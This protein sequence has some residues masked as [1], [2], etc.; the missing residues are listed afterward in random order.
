MSTEPH[1][2][3]GVPTY[4][5]DPY[6]NTLQV[7]VLETGTEDGR[8]WVVLDDTVLFPEGGGQGADHGRLDEIAVLDVQRVEGKIRHYLDRSAPRIE[9]ETSATLTLDWDRRWDHMQQH[10]AQHLL[11]AIAADRFGWPT[12]AFH[13]RGEV[14]DIE[15][16]APRLSRDDLDRLE[17]AVALEITNDVPV[18]TRRVSP[19]EYETMEGVRSRGL[20]AGHRGD[21]RLVE[22]AGIDLNTCGGTHVRSTREIECLKLL[23]TETL[24]G[25]TRLHWVAG[26]RVRRRLGEHEA[27]HAALRKILGAPDA[28]LVDTAQRKIDQ[29]EAFRRR[30]KA[31]SGRLAQAEA[32]VLAGRREVVVDAHYD[33]SDA[34]FLQL[35][36]RS[37]TGSSHGGAA[38]LTATNEK[39]SFFVVAAGG[40]GPED[41]RSLGTAVADALGARGGGSGR[42]F[43]GKLSQFQ[44]RDAALAVLRKTLES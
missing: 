12:T 10:S 35:V 27:R 6:C 19:E 34:G 36:A 38:L 3:A 22:I 43:Q 41:L 40:E 15:L 32:S 24:R 33:D 16:D 21:V 26:E 30:L 2:P 13:L 18:R 37:F 42:I 7:R 8:P 4:E 20:P 29:L 5:R 28:E 39:G 14:C 9:P 1:G 23:H 31:L 17:R 25:G 44:R 11:T